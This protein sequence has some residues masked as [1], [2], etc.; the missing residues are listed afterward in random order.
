MVIPDAEHL[1]DPEHWAELMATGEVTVW[2][3]VPAFLQMLV[4]YL[5]AR[6]KRSELL[7]RFLRSVVLAGDWIPV[8]LPERLRR[9]A[10]GVQFIASGGPTE[11]TIWDIWKYGAARL[12][13]TRR[14]SRMAGR[15]T[16]PLPRTQPAP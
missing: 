6:A 11:T 12:T 14:A 10:P 15:W 8:T 5:E 7:P 13:R 3:S 4:E 9:L 2:N 16:T 1:R